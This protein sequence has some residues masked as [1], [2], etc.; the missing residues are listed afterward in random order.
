MPRKYTIPDQSNAPASGD[1]SAYKI[2]RRR[3]GWNSR[4]TICD[5]PKRAQIELALA[6][7]ASR[8]S[9]GQRYD[10]SADAAY[11]HFENHV[12]E[13]TKA[14]LKAMYLKPSATIEEILAEETP[15]LIERL[16]VYRVGLSHLYHFE[17]EA[18]NSRAATGL[19][20]ELIRIEEI[21]AEQTGELRKM[22][23]EPVQQL[24]LSADFVKF[25]QK[26]MIAL[27]PHP[28]ALAAVVDALRD[29]P[30]LTSDP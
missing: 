21:L 25:R 24:H 12:P 27:R 20:R 15:G 9:V 10:C 19:A 16:A 11:R 2:D 3:S 23:A 1:A 4:C 22:A 17:I 28:D 8:R 26:I 6:R 18:C 14:A 7:G 30:L 13:E 5:H 29:T